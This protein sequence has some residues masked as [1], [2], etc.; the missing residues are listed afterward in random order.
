MVASGTWQRIANSAVL[1]FPEIDQH[2]ATTRKRGE[3]RPSHARI[4]VSVAR[5]AALGTC[6]ARCYPWHDAERRLAPGPFFRGLAAVGAS[7]P[8]HLNRL[9]PCRRRNEERQEHQAGQHA[10]EGNARTVRPERQPATHSKRRPAREPPVSGAACTLSRSTGLCCR[11]EE[12]GRM[13]AFL[14][15]VSCGADILRAAQVC[16]AVQH[17]DG[18]GH[19]GRPTPVRARAEPTADD[20]LEAADVGPH[21]GP[22]ALARRRLP[23]DAALVLDDL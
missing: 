22:P 1:N 21:Q 6:L 23:G 9:C 7:P 18:N 8:K 2:C 10:H 12:V 19:L 20:P 3:V 16:H 5:I 17:T 13:T 4:S 15:P 11:N 14:G